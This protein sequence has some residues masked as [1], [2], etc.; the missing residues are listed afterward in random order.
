MDCVH[1]YQL[2]AGK[3]LL[4]ISA[5]IFVWLPFQSSLMQQ[6]TQELEQ[7]NI[8]GYRHHVGSPVANSPPGILTTFMLLLYPI[9]FC[10]FVGILCKRLISD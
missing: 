7:D 6:L 8:R 3:S 10:K 2:F 5:K 4:L 1:Q 9:Y